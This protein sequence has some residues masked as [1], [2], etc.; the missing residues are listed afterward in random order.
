MMNAELTIQKKAYCNLSKEKI[1]EYMTV[2]VKKKRAT[3]DLNL[4]YVQETHN[5]KCC[6]KSPLFQNQL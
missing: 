6:K 5:R 1:L 2:L 3:Q 4:Q